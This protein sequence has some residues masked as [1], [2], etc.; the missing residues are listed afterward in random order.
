MYIEKI[1]IKKFRSIVDETFDAKN[2]TVFVGNND[3]GKSNILRALNLFFNNQTGLGQRFDFFMDYS[4]L[5]PSPKK[6]AKEISIEILFSPPPTFQGHLKKILL[7]KKWREEGLHSEGEKIRFADGTAIPERSR[8]RVWLNRLRYY[9]VPAIK[10]NDYFSSL[11]KKLYETLYSTIKS[12]LQNAGQQFVSNIQEHTKL[13]SGEL[14][15]KLDLESKIQLPEDLSNLFS[16]L[17]F[18]TISKGQPISLQQRGD[19]IK[20]RHLPVILKFL[21]EKERIHHS[22]GAVRSDSIWGYEEPENNLELIQAFGLA[23]DFEKYSN[24]IQIFLTTHSSA[25]YTIGSDQP[26]TIKYNT[27]KEL[28]NSSTKVSKIEKD[29]IKEVDENL[30]LMP[31]VAP[32]IEEKKNENLELMKIIE[33]L[34]DEKKPV[35][36]VEGQTDKIILENAWEKLKGGVKMPFRIQYAFDRFF[37]GNTFRRGEIFKNN[38]H[39]V[40]I[41]MLDFDEAFEDWFRLIDKNPDLWECRE[42]DHTKG[43]LLKHKKHNAYVFLLPVPAHR[44]NYANKKYGKMSRLSIELLFT[45]NK[46]DGCIEE[47]ELPGG[48]KVKKFKDDKKTEFAN[49]TKS[50]CKEDFCNFDPIFKILDG[51]INREEN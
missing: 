39:N 28:E 20:V 8:I 44:I 7:T 32:Y 47:I 18:E 13:L 15:K 17:D 30:G 3:V 31:I 4:R 36:F 43:L 35:L 45:D 10:S 29:S 14:Y 19:G 22:K 23:K 46:L 21:A 26:E 2:I 50:F 5:A 6:K 42:G 33:D 1:T 25:F 40:F 12:D 48:A 16:T 41:G 24:D 49:V 37:I 9:Y 27:F 34:K 38:S 51:V 11:L